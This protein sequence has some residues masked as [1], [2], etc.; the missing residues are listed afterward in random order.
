MMPNIELEIPIGRRWSVNA[1][2][3]FPWWLFDGDKYSMQILMGGLE[4]RYWLGSKEKRINSECLPDIFSDCMP[5]AGKY[6]L[7]WKED[8][9]Q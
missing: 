8:G 4:G 1:E 2:Y 6:E 7:Q 3:M 5:E 9:Y